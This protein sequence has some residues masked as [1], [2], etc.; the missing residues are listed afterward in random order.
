MFFQNCICTHCTVVQDSIV[1]LHKS[2]Q[3]SY[4]TWIAVVQTDNNFIWGKLVC[5]QHTFHSFQP[6]SGSLVK[7]PK[8]CHRWIQPISYVYRVLII[9]T[10]FWW[11]STMLKSISQ[12]HWSELG[13]GDNCRDNVTTCEDQTS[14]AG[15]CCGKSVLT[16]RPKMFWRPG[17]KCFDTQA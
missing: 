6:F 10:R 3:S 17:L 8:T 7:K 1:T 12:G 2:V 16:P 13:T 4:N 5:H 11:V 9:L 14:V 15:C